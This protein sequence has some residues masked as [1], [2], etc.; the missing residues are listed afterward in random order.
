MCFLTR[1]ERGILNT[2]LFF[3]PPSCTKKK[4]ESDVRKGVFFFLKDGNPACSSP[5]EESHVGGRRV[6]CR[7]LR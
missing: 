1:K 5:A 7:E 2:T 3:F 4:S 6:Q